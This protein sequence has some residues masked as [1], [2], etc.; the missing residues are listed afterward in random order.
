[1]KRKITAFILLFSLAASLLSCSE[2]RSARALMR[3]FSIAYGIDSPIY[4]PDVREGEEGYIN[5]GFFSELYGEGE[6]WVSDFAVVLLSDLEAASE[7]GVFICYTDY[8]ARQVSEMLRRRIELVRSVAAISGLSLP[9]GDFVY[10]E[11]IVVVMAILPRTD[12]AR[13]LWGEIL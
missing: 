5:S 3:E 7:C 4:S 9:D 11:G 13:K 8:D 2:K 12:T 10:R 6:E 1:M